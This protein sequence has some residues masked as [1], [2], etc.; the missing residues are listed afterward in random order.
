MFGTRAHY[1]GDAPRAAARLTRLTSERQ[2]PKWD[3][4]AVAGALLPAEDERALWQGSPL[5]AWMILPHL[6]GSPS[7]EARTGLTPL[8][9]DDEILVH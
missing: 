4:L 5:P 7:R 2:V 8:G 1:P 9:A 6:S 3:V